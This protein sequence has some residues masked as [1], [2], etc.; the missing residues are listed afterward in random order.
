MNEIE[1]ALGDRLTRI[2]K[3]DAVVWPAL[4]AARAADLPSWR[5]VS[6]ALYGAVWNALTGRPAGHGLKDVDL[7]YFDASDLS[8]EAEDAA[9]RL[10]RPFF[11]EPPA[12]VEIRNQARVH[13]WFEQRFGQP[14]PPLRS[15]EEG[16]DRY[17][18]RNHAVG[19]RLCADD[20]L[21]IYAPFGLSEIFALEIRPNRALENRATHA[22]KA[23]R[24]QACWPEL[25]VEPW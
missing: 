21:D 6:G 18:S 3:A 7:A 4:T 13:L 11:G 24:A 8:W 2:L 16:I 17:A 14:Y 20:R 12:P 23:R 22:E 10:A 9:I 15:V 19:V 5:I 1:A 25:T